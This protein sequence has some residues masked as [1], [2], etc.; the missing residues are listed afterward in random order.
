MQTLRPHPNLL[1]QPPHSCKIPISHEDAYPR[2]TPRLPPPGRAQ[3]ASWRALVPGVP[4]PRFLSIR[5]E[6]RPCS[7]GQ[8]GSSCH[9][10]L[11]LNSEQGRRSPPG[12]LLVTQDGRRFSFQNLLWSFPPQW[13]PSAH[14]WVRVANELSNTSPNSPLLSPRAPRRPSRLQGAIMLQLSIP[15]LCA[16]LHL[17]WRQRRD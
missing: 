3:K 1:S 12:L 14:P 2:E 15:L 4:F 13:A 5:H 17:L 10:T 7:Q 16:L 8:S 6:Q 9:S 11:P